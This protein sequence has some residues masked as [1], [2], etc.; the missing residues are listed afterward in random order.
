MSMLC[1]LEG[2]VRG[3]SGIRRNQHELERGFGFITNAA[4]DG[5]FSGI[6]AAADYPAT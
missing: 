2:V 6:Q 5:N 1:S 4:V 3:L